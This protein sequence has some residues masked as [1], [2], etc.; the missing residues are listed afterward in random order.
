MNVI[1]FGLWGQE[2]KYLIGAIDNARQASEFYPGWQVRIYVAADVPPKVACEVRHVGGVVLPA[3][4]RLH[5][6]YLWRFQPLSDGEVERVVFRDLDSRYSRRETDAVAE[7]VASGKGAH[8][9]RDWPF[10]H[11]LL[12][13]GGT[14][15]VI[16][17]R[18]PGLYDA[19]LADNPRHEYGLDERWL[20]DVVWPR[21]RSD[22]YIHDCC[23]G[24]GRPPG[25]EHVGARYD[26][27]HLCEDL[28]ALLADDPPPAP[29]PTIDYRSPWYK[30][31]RR[32]Q[33]VRY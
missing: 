9:M 23:D 7:W 17:G 14:W 13:A 15:G 27:G 20:T 6:R 8:V 32:R 29:P 33:V 3:D 18:F 31:L 2:A 11:G 21:I 19:M 24:W 4:E 30:R 5:N 16:P 1:S 25:V 12:M 10:W 26:S 28:A 22:A